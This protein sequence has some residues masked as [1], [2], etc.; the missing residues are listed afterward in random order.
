MPRERIPLGTWSTVKAHPYVE[1][2]RKKSGA[3]KWRRLTSDEEKN[4]KAFKDLRW[5]A[6]VY[7]RGKTGR[8]ERVEAWA[9]SRAAAIRTVSKKLPD[10]VDS[11][12]DIE[13]QKTTVEEMARKWWAA[14]EKDDPAAK[15]TKDAYKDALDRHVIPYF[16]GYSIQEVT[17]G[18]LTAKLREI[19]QGAPSNAW[20]ARV[21]LKHVFTFAVRRDAIE[22]NPVEGT[23]TFKTRSK[24]P[25]AATLEQLQ[26]VREVIKTWQT[27]QTRGPARGEKLLD[28]LDLM[29][30]AG[31]RTGEALAVR[32]D[33]VQ[34]VAPERIPLAPRFTIS[35]SGTIIQPRDG[36]APYRQPHPKTKAGV[37]TPYIPAQ[38]AQRLLTRIANNPPNEED[39]VFPTRDGRAMSPNNFRSALRRALKGSEFEGTLKPY[40]MRKTAATEVAHEMSIDEAR[41]LLGHTDRR[42]TEKFYAERDVSVPDTSVVLGDLLKRASI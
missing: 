17:T 19:S 39:L 23:P 13:E 5:R 29:L 9:P 31:C 4:L 32:A 28:V 16:G 2:G 11:A 18:L 6:T 34:Q 26:K 37:R 38:M 27:T 33:D 8:R 1:D 20:F 42:T 21:V 25:V 41:A 3:K 24:A 36:G 22:R 10:R 14:Y 15:Q 40:L 35:I 30:V 7:Y 12:L